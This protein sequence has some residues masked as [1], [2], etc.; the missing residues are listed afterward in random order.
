[1]SKYWSDLVT[2]LEP[3]IPGEQ[4]NMTNITNEIVESVAKIFSNNVTL[5]DQYKEYHGREQ[6]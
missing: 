5:D 2:Q 4:P 1:M 6:D 3:Y